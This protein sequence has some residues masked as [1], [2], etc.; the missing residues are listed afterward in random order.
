MLNSYMLNMHAEGGLIICI[1]LL[2]ICMNLFGMP[3]ECMY[4]P[5]GYPC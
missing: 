4:M 3:V 2:S 1:C 5:V